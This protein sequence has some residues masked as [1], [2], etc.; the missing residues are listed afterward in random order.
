[1]L[2]SVG[3]TWTWTA[4]AKCLSVVM[5]AQLIVSETVF[6]ALFGLAVHGRWPTPTEAAGLAALI[7]G[8]VAAT[9]NFYRNNFI[10][11]VNIL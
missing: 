2:S 6:G 7:A 9:R 3:G 10:R 8:V 5:S 11:R 1:M 4:A